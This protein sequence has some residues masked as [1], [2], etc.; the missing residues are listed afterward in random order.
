[1]KN[2]V[3]KFLL[4]VAA[5]FVIAALSLQS[6]SAQTVGTVTPSVSFDVPSNSFT[7]DV[8]SDSEYPAAYFL[9][10]ST[11]DQIQAIY[12]G[13]ILYTPFTHTELFAGTCSAG[14]CVE[15][16]VYRA[17]LKFVADTGGDSLVFIAQRY[18]NADPFQFVSE[19]TGNDQLS[20]TDEEEDWLRGIEPTPTPTPS[21]STGNTSSSGPASPPVCNSTA[22]SA[23]VLNV[24]STGTNSAQLGWTGVGNT[25]HYMIRYG[26]LPGVY[27]YGAPNVGNVTNFTVNLLSAGT[28]Y[29]FQVA[30]VNNC[31]PGSWSNEVGTRVRGN[32][33]QPGPAEG[34]SQQTLGTTTEA[35]PTPSPTATPTATPTSTTNNTTD[36][37]GE[38]NNN[39]WLLLLAIILLLL[40]WLSRR[41]K[42]SSK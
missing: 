7:V 9:F 6:V 30:A 24:L 42:K 37:T 13:D 4:S 40:W 34:F 1:M 16:N 19:D 29:Y 39:W 31:M 5:V 22:P 23:P 41:K 28:Q 14:P 15:D 2:I 35:T 25:T 8:T 10:Y 18:E 33:F 32:V 27:I 26:I 36:T 3:K 21:P 38:T 17:I 20:L 11:P 12:G